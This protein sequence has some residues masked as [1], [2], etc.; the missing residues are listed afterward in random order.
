MSIRIYVGRLNTT[1][2]AATIGHLFEKYG[3]LASA[4]IAT[5]QDVSRGFGYVEMT[6]Q[7]AAE[8]AVRELNNCEVEGSKIKVEYAL[9]P[10]ER[11]NM[12]QRGRFP[13]RFPRF[14][15]FPPYAGRNR[16]IN[17]RNPGTFRSLSGASQP[18]FPPYS[19]FPPRS[20]GP[21]RFRRRMVRR[22][23][24]PTAPLSTTRIHVSNLPYQLTKE[25]L[26]EVFKDYKVKDVVLYHQNFN[27][28]L[29][30]GFG[31]VEFQDEQEQKKVINDHPTIE[32]MTRQCKVH[33]ALV[34][35]QP[36]TQ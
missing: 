31:Y 35:P 18:R 10:F 24:D 20:F 26:A 5:N 4:K 34:N 27:T 2:S 12:L 3:S 11:R 9:A 23:F 17:P 16:F 21:R 7:A 8:R 29:N 30:V 36:K 25:Q 1:T 32:I 19:R 13:R 28:T 15:R 14:S 33:A 22:P 6:D